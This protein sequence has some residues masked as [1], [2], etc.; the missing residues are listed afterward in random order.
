MDN[1]LKYKGIKIK[2]DP[3]YGEYKIFEPVNMEFHP[4]Y[5]NKVLDII[6]IED[7]EKFLKR[8]AKYEID[9]YL[10]KKGKR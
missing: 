3:H 8:K 10:K 2:I 5:G 9:V 7:R 1:I 4:Y 6:S